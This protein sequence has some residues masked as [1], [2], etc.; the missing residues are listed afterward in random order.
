[1]LERTIRADFSKKCGKIK[2]LNGICLGPLFDTPVPSDFRDEYRELGAPVVRTSVADMPVGC[3]P[4]LDMSSIFPDSALDE[5]FYESY[6]F[7]ELDKQLSAIRESGAAIFL[8][9]GEHRSRCSYLP[10]HPHVS[11]EKWAR[12]AEKI[13]LHCNKGWGGGFKLPV[14][15]VEIWPG[16]D[17]P[18]A[19]DGGAA[20]YAEFYRIVATHLKSVFPTLKIGAYSSGGF[21]S[22]NRYDATADE[23]GY[24]D[25]LE[26]F[27]SH[28][29]AR[30]TSAPLDFFSWRCRAESAEELAL[31][32]SYAKNFLAQYGLRKTASIVSELTIEPTDG[33]PALSRSYP[34]SLAAT[35]AVASGTDISMMLYSSLYPYSPDNGLI[36]LDDC[37]TKHKYS[38]FGVMRAYGELLR[39]AS[40]VEVTENFRREL[41]MLA[42]AS[43]E[44]A[45]L[46]I[47]TVG[48]AGMLSVELS[49]GAYKY[50]SIRGMLGGGPR[51]EGFSTEER[52]IPLGEGYFT[53]K[54]GRGEI[55]LITLY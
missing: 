40:A 5:R 54:V 11:A 3:C 6:D 55:Y 39:H 33:P 28:I 41:Y 10:S 43:D 25:F 32:A 31:H 50:Y 27:F 8:A 49:G 35:L 30:D 52:D 14:K 51:G 46:M 24:I 18:G 23:R 42:A 17:L 44:G 53:M 7:S 38:A 4:T 45:A 19:F 21:A 20:A 48:Y 26:K 29:S 1:M 34:S 2:P 12:I 37:R 16:A 36:T 22:L 13:I 47:A 15:M 9:L